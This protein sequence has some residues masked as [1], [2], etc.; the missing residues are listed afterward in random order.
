MS[1]IGSIAVVKSCP[2]GHGLPIGGE[3]DAVA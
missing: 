3:G 2:N 1:G